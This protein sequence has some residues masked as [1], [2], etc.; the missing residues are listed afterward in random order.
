MAK[1][2]YDKE[3][4]KNTDWGGDESTGYLPVRGNRVQEFIKKTLE[5]KMGVF[6]YD[7]TNNRYLV[8]ADNESRDAYLEDPSQ[9]NL[10]LGTF[11]APFNYS[12][13]ILLSTPNYVAILLGAKN[14]YIDFTFDT[15][16]KQGQ[17]VGED[18]ICTYTFIRGSVKKEVV[19]K[20]RTGTSVHFNIDEYLLEGTNTILIGIVGQN[21]LAATTISVTYQVV[22]LTLTDSFDISDVYNLLDNPDAIINVPY[23]ISGVGVKTMEWYLDGVL[24]E[25]VKDEDEIVETSSSRTKYIPIHGL[26][27]GRH[28]VQFR[29]YSVVNGE[30]FYSQVLYRDFIVYKVE[31]L[32]PIIAVAISLPAGSD[33]VSGM[34]T[35]TDIEQYVPYSLRLAVYNPSEALSTLDI[36]VDSSSIASLIVSNGEEFYYDI[37]LS[38]YGNKVLDL[39]IGSVK[40]SI[41]L[42][43]SET[44]TSLKEITDGLTLALSAIG[45][46]NNSYDKDVWEYGNYSTTFNGFSW[47]KISGWVNNRLLISNGASIKT[48]IKPL[49]TDAT[50]SGRTL[51]FEFA[52]R[53]VS[54]DSFVVCNLRN[55]SGVG[56]LITASEI[57]LTSSEGQKVNTKFKSEE[58]IRVSLVINKKSGVTNKL[59]AFIYINGILS[60]AVNFSGTDNFISDK[61]LEFK[62]STEADIELKQLRFYDVA[63][64]SD[65]IL[66]NYILYRDNAQEMVSVYEKNNIYQEGSTSL[67]VDTLLGQLP[68]MIVTGDIPAL[69][70]TTDKNLE[71]V[72]DV[73]YTNLQDPKRSFKMVNAV[74]RPQGTSS[75]SYPK[76]NF[77]LYTK[78]RDNTIVYDSDGKVIVDKLYSFKE[79]AQPVK[80]WCMKADYAES[81]GT[82]NTGIARLWNDV[83]RDARIDGSYICRTKAQE[84]AIANGFNYDVRTTVDG[85]PILMFYRP[86]ANDDLIFIGKYNFNNDKSTESVFG[87]EG[88]P[89]F[90]NSRMQCW[91]VLNNGNHLALF[92]DTNNFDEEWEDAF[93]A[94]YPD[95]GSDADT[96]DLKAFCEWVVST[97]ENVEKFRTEKWDHLD[98]YKIAAYYIYLMR[99]GAVDQTVKNAMLTTEDGVHFFYINYDNDTILGVR[100]DGLL[101]YPPTIDRQTLDDS[102]TST[103]YCYAGHD[104]TLWNNLEAD[105]EFMKIVSDVDNALY[106]AGLSYKNVIN[107]FDSEQSDK[108]CERIYNQ[109]AQYKYIGPYANSRINNLY[110]L[111]GSRKAHRR[112]WLSRRFNYLDAK[113]ASGEYRSNTF[114]IKLGGAPI[115]VSFSITSGFDMNYGYGVNNVPIETGV[116]LAEGES[117]TFTTRQVL[118]LGDPLRIYSAVNLKEIDVHDFIEYLSTVNMD[119]IYNEVLGTRLKKLIL[120][121]DVSSDER[122]NSSLTEISGL[123]SAKRLEYLDISGYKGISYLDLTPFNY[124]TT[125]KAFQS[126][127]TSVDF[128]E[129]SL[130]ALA[131]LPETLQA[132]VLNSVNITQEN[133]K[134][135]NTW[136]SLRYLDIRNCPNF[137][138]N[139]SYFQSWYREKSTPNRECS[140]TVHGINWLDITPE[141]LLEIGQ[142]QLDGGTLS[143]K[144]YIK[145]TSS[146]LEIVNQ[147]RDIFGPNCFNPNNDLYISAPSEIY[148][149]GPTEI[150]EGDTAQYT[151]AVFSEFLGTVSYTIAQGN[152]GRF[153]INSTTGLLTSVE[154]EYEEKTITIRAIHRST[155]GTAETK[156]LIVTVKPRVYPTMEI[157]GESI[158]NQ[159]EEYHVYNLGLTPANYNGIFT[160]KWQI[161]GSIYSQ[162]YVSISESNEKRC[163]LRVLKTTVSEVSGTLSV[164]M[165][166]G[167]GKT[168]TVSL[169]IIV[170]DPNVIMTSSSNPEVMRICYEQGWA[171]S[172]LKMTKQEAASVTSIGTVFRGNTNIKAFPEFQYFTGVTQVDEY[173]FEGCTNL[174]LIYIPPGDITIKSESFDKCP[175]IEINQMF[176][177]ATNV[178]LESSVFTGGWNKYDYI[179][180]P[181]S[182]KRVEGSLFTSSSLRLSEFE[183]RGDYIIFSPYAYIFIDNLI[184]GS[185]IFNYSS[186][187][188]KAIIGKFT[189]LDGLEHLNISG[190]VLDGFVGDISLPKSI[191][192]L[193]FSFLKGNYDFSGVR[194]TLEEGGDLTVR[195]GNIYRKSRNSIYRFYSGNIQEVLDSVEGVESGAFYSISQEG[196]SIVIGDNIKFF[197]GNADIDGADTII[198]R[199]SHITSLHKSGSNTYF[200]GSANNVIIETP[201][202]VISYEGLNASKSVRILGRCTLGGSAFSSYKGELIEI[203]SV[204]N[205]GRWCFNNAL[206]VKTLRINSNIAPSLDSQVFE[207]FG[208]RYMGSNTASTGE[209]RFII[210]AGSTGYD[211]GQWLDP[212]CNPDKCGFTLV[213]EV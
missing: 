151:A 22:N 121:V 39:K 63:L 58:N 104:S 31:T 52:T 155:Q 122:R 25:F 6:H 175:N 159:D 162:G 86:T 203:N 83:M 41:N 138:T 134:I 106:A 118:N 14:N 98:V 211:T 170:S 186:G 171:A 128:A 4:N 132:L 110:M 188:A 92:Q 152:D 131:E 116:S 165:T 84:S 207:Y 183:V 54:N 48:N 87:F 167:S 2:Y 158:I 153:T 38:S 24:L 141:D 125:L 68:V 196:G 59:L 96:T 160:I 73:E 51:E 206:N 190:S 74:M 143:L 97:K 107:I 61:I 30:R 29:A 133:L 82:H 60:G 90:D 1:E 140:L 77:R 46:T 40:Y 20:Y 94:R 105:E 182:V 88:I 142:L 7:E 15:K 145:L 173:A 181:D 101:I 117:H 200:N 176:D 150:Y 85:F 169:R 16:N 67:S 195:D 65:Q 189:F 35:I 95:V 212:L 108:W 9:V 205:I 127:L 130:L 64:T 42:E 100:N 17:S 210:P 71:I 194:F 187:V 120:G 49:E 80:T 213:E 129:G 93:E 55:S 10:I 75:M 123:I 178:T 28:N 33:I 193:A 114:E 119:K 5:N 191:N 37:M 109:D 202:I 179:R 192:E 135:E 208:G 139:F 66:N 56:I 112:W 180:L 70:N 57:V 45:K 154:K 199:S 53:N 172:S 72:V 161:T 149:T 115:G 50:M 62:S 201:D 43:V 147:L 89:G 23:T 163:T 81:S 12:A 157:I 136:A 137:K 103:V 79:G 32:N 47:N 99:F 177:K 204:D 18:V 144:G 156:D 198:L 111:Q 113:F 91:E 3:I 11:D 174:G 184:V 13:E 8:F 19:Q 166:K 69:E 27:E 78:R 26:S 126:G 164:T 76:K 209:N 168:T 21:T 44:E 185:K 102:F 124:F 197:E 36:L 146:S 34:L 148:L